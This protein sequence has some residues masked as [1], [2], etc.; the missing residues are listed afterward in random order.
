MAPPT[1]SSLAVALLGVVAGAASA[2]EIPEGPPLSTDIPEFFSI[3]VSNPAVLA[4]HNKVMTF[5][6]N[7]GDQHLNLAPAG[8]PT[9]DTLWLENGRIHW[10]TIHAVIDLEVSRPPLSVGRRRDG[11][12]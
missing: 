11:P 5:H 10:D 3:F 6:P 1:W 7:G 4:I 2:C 8:N 9:G 12:G